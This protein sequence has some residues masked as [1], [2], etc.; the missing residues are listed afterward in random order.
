MDTLKGLIDMMT[1]MLADAG[2][3]EIGSVDSAAVR[4]PLEDAFEPEKTLMED[5]DLFP[6]LL[7]MVGSNGSVF[8][9]CVCIKGQA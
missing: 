1:S 2:S 4:S 6:C 8:L 5:G 3:L 9:V 7:A